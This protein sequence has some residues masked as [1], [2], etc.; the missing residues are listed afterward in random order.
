MSVSILVV[1]DEPDVAGTR[2]VPLETG[3][4]EVY[5]QSNVELVDF[6]E[7]PIEGIT[8]T[9]IK[10]SGREYEFDIIIYAT[11]F[12]AI[13]G[14][15]DRI[16]IRGTDGVRL[17]DCRSPAAGA[18]DKSGGSGSNPGS[19]PP[20]RD[21]WFADSPLEGRRFELLVPLARESRFLAR[22]RFRG[23]LESCF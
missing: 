7:T 20:L 13:T 18:S 12:D 11:G 21:R 6:N 3:Y 9:G 2:R 4:Y 8:P 10:T 16:D 19:T 17:K 15:Y 22:T 1:D 23:D 14:A 5:N